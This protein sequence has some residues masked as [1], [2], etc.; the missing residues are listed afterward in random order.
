MVVG[1]GGKT[2]SKIQEQYIVE[3]PKHKMSIIDFLE[4]LE[5]LD[6]CNLSY[7]KE[8]GSEERKSFVLAI[9]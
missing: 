8:D 6:N 9:I 5:V 3:M 2:A 4:P 7:E 1:G